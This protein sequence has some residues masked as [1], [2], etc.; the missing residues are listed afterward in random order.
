M[1]GGAAGCGDK[2]DELRAG[3]RVTAAL[4]P[5]GFGRFE[6]PGGAAAGQT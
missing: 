1:V 3:S 4:D 5:G 2:R 6:A